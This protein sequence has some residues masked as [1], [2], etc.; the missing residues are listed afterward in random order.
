MRKLGLALGLSVAAL[1]S[2]CGGGGGSPGATQDMYSITVRAE[3]TSLPINIGHVGAGIGAKAPYTTTI[4]VD[5]KEGA[6]PI[7]GG[8]DI[9]SCNVSG[10]LDTGALYYL[11]GDPSHEDS[12]KNPLAYRSITLGA[13]SGGNSFHFHA[14]DQAGVATVT[15]AVT[16]PRDK[17]VYSASVNITVGGGTGTGKPAS[18][19][20]VAKSSYLGSQYNVNNI[21]G[22]IGINAIV[23]DDAVQPVPNPSAANVQ[24]RILGNTSAAL[25]ARL[26]SGSQSGSVIQVATQGGVALFSLSSGPARGAILLEL[27]ADRYD[28]NVTNGIQDPIVQWTSIPVVDGVSSLPLALS[29]V[30]LQAN[31]GV[32]FA[33]ALEATNGTPPYQWTVVSGALP[34]GLSLSGDGVIQGT[35][36]AE[37]GT[38]VAKVRVTDAFGAYQEAPVTI[39]LSGTPIKIDTTTISAATGVP[40]SYALMASGGVSPYTWVVTGAMPPG[41]SLSSNGMISGTPTLAGNYAVS[42]RVTDRA[43]ATAQGNLTM[44]I[45][46]PLAISTT[47]I[48]AATAMPFSEVLQAVGGVSPYTWTRLDTGAVIPDGVFSGSYPV[49]GT[50]TIPIRLTDAAGTSVKA[51]LTVTVAG[52][53]VEIGTKSISASTGV[54]FSYVLSVSGG[55]SP[56][57]WA[58]VGSM[59]PGLSLSSSGLISGTPTLAGN[60]TVVISVTDRAGVTAQGNLT[61]TI[62]VPLAI[63]TTS[64]SAATGMPFSYVLQAVGDVSPYTW[65]R[66]D[67]GATITNGVFSGAYASAGT[68]TIP[69][70]LTD[71]AGTSVMGTLVVTVSGASIGIASTSVSA[72]TGVPFSYMLAAAGGTSPY[73]W[74]AVGPMPPGL[75]LSS[76]GLIAGTPTLAGI[77]TVAVS[78]TDS[79]GA[80]GHGNLTI[81]IGVPLAITTASITATTGQPFGYALQAIGGVSPYTWTRLDTGQPIVNGV[82]TGPVNGAYAAAG[83][84]A[85]PVRLTD[86]VGTSVTGTLNIAV[87]DPS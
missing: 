47:S 61:I 7:Q 44:T 64:I 52:A 25:N 72:A 8:K 78:V 73:T 18:V 69:I 35:P 40:Y 58:S 65:T 84:Y 39:T 48:S 32:P 4:Y 10:G 36:V 5:A 51:T 33:Q 54:P 1:L 22:N 46:V 19:Y 28:N 13:N 82:I 27:K 42:V 63:S 21:P 50:Y 24:I 9:F 2:A 85:V 11:D 34:A 12:N 75:A 81:S 79:T 86:A 74:A 6:D 38:Y 3:K 43:G 80:T 67:T 29:A 45:G 23:M 59:P 87:S 37:P 68:Y 26:L 49:A 70:R 62:G 17:R 15:C 55:V 83:T 14:G 20:A 31:N 71:A 41:L 60:Y 66:L 16:D 30:T 76:A 53:S 77:Y 57:T 56:Y